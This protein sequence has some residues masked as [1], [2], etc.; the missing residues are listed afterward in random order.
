MKSLWNQSFGAPWLNDHKAPSSDM[1]VPHVL[2]AGH[3][4]IFIPPKYVPMQQQLHGQC[5]TTSMWAATE[6]AMTFGLLKTRE[7]ANL[8]LECSWRPGLESKENY[9]EKKKP[10]KIRKQMTK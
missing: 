1:D 3:T 5:H 10:T 4:H 7:I 9:K 6:I 2:Q 8:C